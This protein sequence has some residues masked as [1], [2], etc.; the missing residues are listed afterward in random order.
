MVA[1]R[2][3]RERLRAAGEA[4]TAAQPA[5]LRYL[6]KAWKRYES[7]HED[8]M[9][10][11]GTKVIAAWPIPKV[12]AFA[13]TV[14]KFLAL[15]HAKEEEL[16]ETLEADASIETEER[17][18]RRPAGGAENDKRGTIPVLPMHG[19]PAS[20]KLTALDKRK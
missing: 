10:D 2:E 19:K 5:L 12:E 20:T 3:E 8:W 11:A 4:W 18:D 7:E 17:D 16:H 15:A 9:Q 6:T 13:I 14:V 1:E